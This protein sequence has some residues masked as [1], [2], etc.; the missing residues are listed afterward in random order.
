MTS[1]ALGRSSG[2]AESFEWIAGTPIVMISGL[3]SVE[4]AGRGRRSATAS[5][6]RSTPV[7]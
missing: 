6:S 4:N 3:N 2:G 7:S 5:T 1:A